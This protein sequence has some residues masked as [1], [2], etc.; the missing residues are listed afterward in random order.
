MLY[1]TSS[2][3]TILSHPKKHK[4]DS[5]LQTVEEV[6]TKAGTNVVFFPFSFV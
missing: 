4:P 5:I 6:H 1:A 3:Y 2:A